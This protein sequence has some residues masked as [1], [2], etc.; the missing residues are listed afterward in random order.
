MT[1]NN[2]EGAQDSCEDSC[3]YDFMLNL[4][5]DAGG[6]AW[7]YFLKVSDLSIDKKGEQDF[8][9]L[10]D[11]ET[12]NYIRAAISKRFPTD[13]LM[14]EEYGLENKEGKKGYTWIIDPIDGTNCFLNGLPYWCV[15]IALSRH[16]ELVAGAIF[17]PNQNELFHAMKGDGAKINE[18]LVLPRSGVSVSNTFFCLGYKPCIDKADYLEIVKK[19]VSK[20]GNPMRNGSGALMAAY[21]ATYKA[22]GFYEAHI[23]SWDVAAGCIIA[24]E[25]GCYVSDYFTPESLLSG[26]KVLI[27]PFNL[28]DEVKDIV[29]WKD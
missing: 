15:S 10:A 21:A 9:S 7:Q 14:G 20:N 18:K 17:D 22:C 19:L 25:S 28:L 12:E 1:I 11:K 16:G 24:Q 8:V 13:S 4:A 29:N 5:R 2:I 3:R 6:I 23:N 27:C 26:N